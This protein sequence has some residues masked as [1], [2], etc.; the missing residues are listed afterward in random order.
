MTLFY[1]N[2]MASL[3]LAGQDSGTFDLEPTTVIQGIEYDD[4]EMY[5]L[6]TRYSQKWSGYGVYR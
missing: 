5:K 1:D 6:G 2:I 3:G 4:Q